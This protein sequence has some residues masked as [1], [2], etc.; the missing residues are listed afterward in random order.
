M[1]TLLKP[2]VT[3]PPDVAPIDIFEPPEVIEDPAE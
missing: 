2:V 1:Y 3:T